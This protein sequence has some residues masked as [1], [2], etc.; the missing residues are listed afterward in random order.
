[1][2]KEIILHSSTQ[3]LYPKSLFSLKSIDCLLKFFGISRVAL[4]KLFWIYVKESYE[5]LQKFE[6]LV[7]DKLMIL[8]ISL[9]SV[10]IV[11]PAYRKSSI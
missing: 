11:I 7:F 1:M 8:Q 5:L 3:Y 6:T 10:E 2:T 9:V 4:L